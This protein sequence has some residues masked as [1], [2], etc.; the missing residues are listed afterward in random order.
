MPQTAHRGE[1]ADSE[2]RAWVEE[3]KGPVPEAQHEATELQNR[4]DKRNDAP[5]TP[6]GKRNSDVSIVSTYWHLFHYGF[7]HHFD[8]APQAV[9]GADW[10]VTELAAS[11]RLP[12]VARTVVLIVLRNSG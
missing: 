6:P 8:H 1:Q 10:P 9:V 4:G 2:S 12:I 11:R 7:G 3:R 5:A